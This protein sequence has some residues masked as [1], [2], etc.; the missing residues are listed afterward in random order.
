ME[1]PSPLSFS[2]DEGVLDDRRR[3]KKSKASAHKGVYRCGR[4]WKSQIQINGVQHYLGVFDTEQEAQKEY[5]DAAGRLRGGTSTIIDSS[6]IEV[7]SMQRHTREPHAG[8]E[9]EETTSRGLS[10]TPISREEVD[11]G[12]PVYQRMSYSAYSADVDVDVRHQHTSMVPSTGDDGQGQGR[13][14]AGAAAL[15]YCMVPSAQLDTLSERIALGRVATRLE[16]AQSR[17]LRLTAIGAAATASPVRS[18]QRDVD[19]LLSQRDLLTSYILRGIDSDR[20]TTHERQQLEQEQEQEYHPIGY[21]IE[22]LAS[23]DV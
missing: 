8:Y 23:Y 11:T 12:S 2:A 3:G 4:K 18:T 9:Y 6:P 14:Q 19:Q 20:P 15:V 17:L 22:D 1:T 7:V 21:P 5:Q 16:I 10:A 13:G